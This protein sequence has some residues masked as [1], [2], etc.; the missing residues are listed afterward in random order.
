M[1]NDHSDDR[2]RIWAY[3]Q[4][5]RSEVFESTIGRLGYLVR[6][7]PRG[8]RALN[9]GVG[10]GVFEE[11]ALASGVEVFSLD[12]DPLTVERLQSRLGLSSDHARVGMANN[13]PFADRTFDAVVAS[14]LFEHL[15]IEALDAALVEIS[16]V[17]VPNGKLIGTVPSDEDLN[18][19]VT[20]C[21]ECGATFHRWGHR[22]SF[23]ADAMRRLLVTRFD[24]VVVRQKILDSWQHLN[25]RGRT[26]SLIRRLFLLLGRP[27]TGRNLVFH[28][29]RPRP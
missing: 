12:P 6:Q 4:G 22:Q 24:E 8:C 18:L 20:A 9:I 7:L 5:E 25:W 26:I 27:G 19:Q 29:A 17:L 14:E 10:G 23:D 11:L 13:L 15:T 2:D 3:F 1:A 21:P 16:R 28:A